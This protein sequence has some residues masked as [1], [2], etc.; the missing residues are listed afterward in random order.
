LERF[1]RNW[2][3]NIIEDI[4]DPNQH[5]SL[6]GYSTT[7]ALAQLLHNWLVELEKPKR[8]VRILFIDY[9]K[10]F[11]RI[12]HK[13]L[14]SKLSNLDIPN[15]LLRWLASFLTERPQRIKIG[16]TFSTWSHTKAGVPQGTLLGPVSFI[17]HINDLKTCTNTVKYVD[18]TSLW[19]SC[20]IAGTD[21]VLQQA[22][23]EVL[24]WSQANNMALN[25]EKTKAMTICF[26][27]SG[28]HLNPITIAGEEIESVQQFKLL[29]VRIN[30][31][32]TWDD[33]V[34]YMCTKA[35][36]R[37]YF[38]TLLQRAGVSQ[39]DL[40]SI[41][42]SIVR[43]MLEYGAVIWHPGLTKEQCKLIEHVQKRALRIIFHDLDYKT[44]LQ[45][46]RLESL[47]TRREN[48]CEKFFHEMESDTH[49]LHTILPPKRPQRNLRFQRTYE[50]PKMR[51]FRLKKSPVFYGLYKFQ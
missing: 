10:A 41:Y 12:D 33:H 50:V 17:L 38:I 16:N 34:S 28:T 36:Q 29:G 14:M 42:C 4:I 23:D 35:S 11:D 37:L 26:S 20:S 9:R 39:S 3:L 44:A 40:V 22:A 21:S 7:T 45:T 51:T 48:M 47:N 1:P 43:S 19:E 31:K 25:T 49:P 30:S 24:Q 18:D 8:A 27:K 6:P 2:L 5:G 15:F 13:I 32:L 46:A